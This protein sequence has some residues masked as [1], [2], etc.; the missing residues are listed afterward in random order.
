MQQAACPGEDGDEEMGVKEEGEEEDDDDEEEDDAEDGYYMDPC[1]VAVVASPPGGGRAAST[2]RRRA[3][4]EKERTKLR[5]R[6][7]RAITG[8]ILAGL[9]QHGNY[10]LRARADINEVIAALAREAGWVVL[11]DGTTFPSSSQSA[12]AA[13]AAAQVGLS[14]SLWL[15]SSLPTHSVTVCCLLCSR[16]G[17][18][19]TMSCCWAS[20]LADGHWLLPGSQ[21]KSSE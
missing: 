17:K 16:L 8:R 21:V 14:F 1:P 2:G 19:G 20:E 18:K 6:Q 13:T 15:C 7:R 3:R 10:S 4:E 11:H 9:R 12:A 5:E